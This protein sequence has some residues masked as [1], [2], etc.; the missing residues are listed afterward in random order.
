MAIPQKFLDGHQPESHGIGINMI[1]GD[2]PTFQ[3]ELQ[4]APDNGSGGPGAFA[5]IATLPPLGA[6]ATY[7][8]LLPNDNAFRHYR[9]RH[10]GPGY[11]PSLLWSPIA[12]G[13]PVRLEGPAAAGGLI[14]LYPLRRDPPMSDGD[15]AVAGATNDG[16]QIVKEGKIEG[17]NRTLTQLVTYLVP[18]S[19]WDVWES[20]SQPHAWSVDTGD[21]S[22]A[23]KETSIVFSGDAAAK[24]AF[25]AG[26]SAGTY[27]G[28]TTNDLTKGAFCVP[29]RPG[30]PCTV[31]I[32]SRVSSIATG[33]AY[34]ITVNHNAARTLQS[35]KTIAYRA[36]TTYQVDEFTF[37]P[38]ATSEAN[39]ELKIEFT[40]GSTTATDYWV[41]S[42]R[43]DEVEVKD[44]FDN[45]TKSSAFTI[46]WANGPRQKVTLAA[47]S[48]V[49]TFTNA[50]P[51]AKNTLLVMQDAT[52]SHVLPIFDAT[53]M[54]SNSGVAP[55]L[56]TGPGLT[57]ELDLVAQT[58]PSLRYHAKAVA[59]GYL[60]PTP[61][62]TGTPAATQISVASTTHNINM[63]ATV[64]SGELLQMLVAWAAS[65]GTVTT[66][67][68]W[69]S[70]GTTN[71]LSGFAK[72][73]DGTEGGT[74]VDVITAN[75]VKA[76]AQTYRITTW[77]G[78]VLGGVEAGFN[79][80]APGTSADPP[81][82]TP[83]WGADRNLWLAG[84]QV[85]ANPAITDPAN[86]GTFQQ[87]DDGSVAVR[88]RTGRR[89]LFAATENPDAFTWTG[90]QTWT[91]ITVAVR[92]PG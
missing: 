86:Y 80:G 43:I 6:A 73:S 49:C 59:L 31:K 15:W 50:I 13:K 53:V 3:V 16:K 48:L 38:P 45:G 89:T 84:V 32:A 67:S 64:V 5:T 12:R 54:W 56:S 30:V 82:R 18:N 22:V 52:G 39:A 46:D 81:S 10:I 40:R 42:L 44:L 61:S 83:A 70:L 26:G 62:V 90:S 63:P 74:T 68:G 21:S 76:A 7:I 91:A 24:F 79:S 87:T 47:S 88:L 34:R 78:V 28:F 4:R 11:D 23:A 55:T 41:D 75:S 2:P 33:Q 9:W 37:T 29:L 27:R 85:T 60:Q 25:G 20:A 17:Q 66:P 77:Y 72:V 92:P 8:D 58:T 71:F 35:I 19:E 57:D 51:G 69:A 36:A 14:S 65:P 1:P